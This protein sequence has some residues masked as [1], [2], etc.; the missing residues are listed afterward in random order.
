MVIQNIC[1]SNSSFL[2]SGCSIIMADVG[3]PFLPFHSPIFLLKETQTVLWVLL[4]LQLLLLSWLHAF[5][6]E[7]PEFLTSY[8]E[9]FPSHG[10][11]IPCW[12]VM[13]S[14][15]ECTSVESA[16]DH[17][18]VILDHVILENLSIQLILG[19][20][21][22]GNSLSCFSHWKFIIN[23]LVLHTEDKT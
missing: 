12:L 6:R 5:I 2:W 23:K 7:L 21:T 13:W 20:N 1:V 9:C 11:G 18:M 19:A 14:A 8:I 15:L 17:G 16:N 4:Y 10:H 22:L 3:V